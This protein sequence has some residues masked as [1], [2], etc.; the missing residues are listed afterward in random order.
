MHLLHEHAVD[1]RTCCGCVTT[2]PSQSWSC[3]SRTHQSRSTSTRPD[4]CMTG[5]IQ[6][7]HFALVRCAQ[8]M[9]VISTALVCSW[10]LYLVLF[11]SHISNTFVI[12]L[13]P[14]YSVMI[15]HYLLITLYRSYWTHGYASPLVFKLYLLVHLYPSL[16]STESLLCFPSPL[17]S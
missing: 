14:L 6:L 9:P 5:L 12:L 8:A 11:R 3:H 4:Y 10:L 1:M 7:V 15:T 16:K 13:R 2:I 17:K